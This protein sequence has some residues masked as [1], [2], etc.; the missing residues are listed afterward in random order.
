VPHLFSEIEKQQEIEQLKIDLNSR[1]RPLSKD[2]IIMFQSVLNFDRSLLMENESVHWD[3]EMLD[4]F[5]ERFDWSGLCKLKQLPIDAKFLRTYES[6][7]DFSTL[8]YVKQI[9]WNDE[10]LD[11]YID[12]MS[13]ESLST[14]LYRSFAKPRLL[15]EWKEEVDWLRISRSATFDFT[16]ELLDEFADHWNWTELS[17]NP[18][19]TIDVR[20]M[21]KYMHKLDFD[22][23]SSNPACLQLILEFPDHTKWNW[24]RVIM[25][26]G[27]IYNDELFAKV[28]PYFEK[29]HR[30][31]PTIS[32]A[33][34]KFPILSFLSLVFLCHNPSV[35]FFIQERFG[36]EIHWEMISRNDFVR[37]PA[38]WL[39][40]YKGRF[41]WSSY[42]FVK[43]H[44]DLI[45]IDFV[46][47]NLDLFDFAKSGAYYLPFNMELINSLEERINWNWLSSCETF[48]WHWSFI[49][50]HWDKFN[51]YRLATNKAVYE[52][53]L[54]HFD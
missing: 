47:D 51:K 29:Q 14:F 2:D 40:K 3:R 8:H 25:N 45:T 21:K 19:L 7:I 46:R 42:R 12:R 13:W 22:L 52:A 26:R 54:E 50:R 6:Y 10:L 44:Q 48:K 23:L 11:K 15:R 41:D 36:K 28:F 4:L 31:D 53:M 5:K 35:Q 39:E 1:F 38:E 49:E 34:R 16:D 30:A 17:K 24:R 20:F 32:D 18:N 9:Q 43:N 37:L 33:L 27:M